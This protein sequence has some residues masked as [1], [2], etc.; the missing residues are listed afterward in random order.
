MGRKRQD[1]DQ[2]PEQAEAGQEHRSRRGRKL[3]LLLALA[4]G[5][6]YLLRR[7]QRKADSTSASGTRPPPPAAPTCLA[8]P[9]GIC[10]QVSATPGPPRTVAG[11]VD[12]PHAALR[13]MRTGQP[14]GFRS[15][16]PAGLPSPERPGARPRSAARS[17]CCSA[18]WSASPP[19]PTRP[20]PR[21]RRLLRPYHTAAGEIELAAAPWTSSSATAV[22]AVFGAP[23]AHEDDPERASAAPSACWPPSRS[24]TRPTPASTWPWG[25]RHHR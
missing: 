14:G 3:A 11:P 6:A 21:R 13:S 17:R 15:A 20:T 8:T 24:S 10:K 18:T 2:E 23:V 22:V 5:V 16:G 7:N 4:G 25:R 12:F 19:A 9:P 1:G